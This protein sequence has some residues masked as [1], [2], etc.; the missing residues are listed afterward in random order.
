M[1]PH[2]LCLIGVLAA[3]CSSDGAAPTEPAPAGD[4]VDVGLAPDPGPT[5]EDVPAPPPPELEIGEEIPCEQVG[6]PGVFEEVASQVG[7]TLGQGGGVG[8]GSTGAGVAVGDFDG[9]GDLDI[10]FT[11]AGAPDELYLTGGRGPM[12]FERIVP[13]KGPGNQHQGAFAADADRDGDLDLMVTPI[14]IPTGL[15]KN[16]GH[17]RFSSSG[18]PIAP[19]PSFVEPC[20]AWGDMDGDGLLDL[21]VSGGSSKFGTSESEPGGPDRLFRAEL[22]GLMSPVSLPEAQPNGQTFLAAFVDTDNDH[23][24]DIYVV[25]DFGMVVQPNRLLRNDGGEFTDVSFES[26]ADVAVWGM[27]LAVGDVNLDGH[28][29][30]FTPSMPPLHDVLLINE[31]DGTFADETVARNAS[32][33]TVQPGVAWGAIFI[34]VDGDGDED[35]FVA[36]GAHAALEPPLNAPGQTNVLLINEGESFVDGSEAAGLAGDASSRSPVEADLNA[37]GF[38]D[39]VVGNLDSPPYVYLNGC[40]P[41][42]TWIGLT[43]P[44]AA[45]RLSPIGARVTVEAAGRTHI[46]EI[47]SGSEGLH[48]SGPSDLTIG[49]GDATVVDRLEVRWP[50]G[51]VIEAVEIPVRRWVSLRP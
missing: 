9:D 23:D 51:R 6:V 7:I 38:P 8:Q 35:L 22:N 36:H 17:G 47:A 27:G 1:R 49:L 41:D 11:S 46:R 13:P 44:P 28:L 25:N 19:S 50:T 21:L 10:Y 48:S 4:T 32:S 33:I 43:F 3:A 20:V 29:D 26:D 45:G 12:K 42:R 34:D 15:L 5:V 16:D 37:D 24:L 18:V 39:L 2:L 40:S 14:G 30:L 31:Q